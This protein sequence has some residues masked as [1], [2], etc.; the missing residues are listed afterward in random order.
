MIPIEIRVSQIYMY[1]E[2]YRYEQALFLTESGI[3]NNQCHQLFLLFHSVLFNYI[4]F[5]I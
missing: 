1:P 2:V 3:K 4:H 5:L